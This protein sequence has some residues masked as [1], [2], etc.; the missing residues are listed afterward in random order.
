MKKYLYPSLC[1]GLM[2]LG[3]VAANAATLIQLGP[4]GAQ[5]Y[6]AVTGFLPG[7][8]AGGSQNFTMT[9]D[10]ISN[11]SGGAP[12]TFS[13]SGVSPAG[14]LDIFSSSLDMKIDLSP[15]CNPPQ[16]P[17]CT[18]I[19]DPTNPNYTPSNNILAC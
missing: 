2:L 15:P 8:T 6:M 18:P 3:S 19:H 9:F 11:S 10:N 13:L 14:P 16:T 12:S 1:G 5:G 17:G 7:A 4:E